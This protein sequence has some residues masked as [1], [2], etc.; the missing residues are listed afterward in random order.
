M[1][2]CTCTCTVFQGP[3]TVGHDVA[4]AGPAQADLGFKAYFGV[5]SKWSFFFS[6]YPFLDGFEGKP[7]G[8]PRYLGTSPKKDTH[9]ERWT[10]ARP[11]SRCSDPLIRLAQQFWPFPTST[12]SPSRQ[13]QRL[14][15]RKR[16]EPLKGQVCSVPDFYG[17]ILLIP[18]VHSDKSR[19]ALL[20][21]S[22]RLFALDRAP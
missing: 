10:V 12:F 5:S 13:G 9:M 21:C 22:L 18:S 19:S 1:H 4:C 15:P 16:R 3:G 14:R 20:P 8:N 2:L 17:L 11:V 6:E 7:T